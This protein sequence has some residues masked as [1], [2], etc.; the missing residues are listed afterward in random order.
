M[1]FIVVEQCLA[2]FEAEALEPIF[3][4]TRG[5]LAAC[6]PVPQAFGCSLKDLCYILPD[7]KCTSLS[8]D[9]LK[10]GRLIVSNAAE[11]ELW[12]ARKS[13]F[14]E[15]TGAEAQYGFDL[16]KL[17][18]GIYMVDSNAT[19]E[20]LTPDFDS[21]SANAD[22]WR[23]TFRNGCT[24]PAETELLMHMK[25]FSQ[26]PVLPV[27]VAKRL[28]EV[29][30]KFSTSGARAFQTQIHA[31]VKHTLMA[32]VVERY[33]AQVKSFLQTPTL[34]E[35]YNIENS[36]IELTG[37]QQWPPAEGDT[38]SIEEV[39]A[40]A[41]QVTCSL[42]SLPKPGHATRGQFEALPGLFANLAV[43]MQK[44]REASGRLQAFRSFLADAQ[45][46]SDTF[47]NSSSGH[48]LPRDEVSKLQ[49]A[50]R[51]AQLWLPRTEKSQY[52]TLGEWPSKAPDCK[53][54]GYLEGLIEDVDRF[55]GKALEAID[56]E[57]DDRLQ[58]LMNNCGAVVGGAPNGAS[59]HGNFDP[60]AGGTI[61]EHFQKT[62]DK[63]ELDQIVALC[64]KLSE[65]REV[66]A[67]HRRSGEV[68]DDLFQRCA[69]LLE[70]ARVTKLECVICRTIMKSRK[71]AER[72]HDAVANFNCESESETRV[73]AA[74][75]LCKPLLAYIRAQY[76][77]ASL[78]EGLEPA[79]APP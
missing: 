64:C 47:H 37:Q 57:H 63:Y 76:K 73:S 13:R 25:R 74:S 41:V 48:S 67:M 26:D 78:E 7:K 71:P 45:A 40:A 77:V 5:S 60:N 8:R 68:Q 46:L 9:V 49:N 12:G 38:G 34:E 32:S 6:W 30:Q 4:F 51:A 42:G 21:F 3:K 53:F 52:D 2:K 1:E 69:V 70:K 62:L 18:H 61:M 20:N 56:M 72:I 59:W 28:H 65:G 75:V 29:G 39:C 16:W 50:S 17:T 79:I 43:A 35:A 19:F 11:D 44:N 24:V 36:I 14:K 22:R 10:A 55:A 15:F 23:K 33:Y 27:E 58:K 66:H 54:L 31:Q